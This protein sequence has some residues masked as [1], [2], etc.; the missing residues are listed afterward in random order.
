MTVVPCF[1]GPASR[2]TLPP[3]ARMSLHAFAASSTSSATWP[4]PASSYSF[5]RF[6]T[7]CAYVFSCIGISAEL[8]L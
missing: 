8:E 3:R 5:R 4:L 1:I 7:C 2:T 6:C